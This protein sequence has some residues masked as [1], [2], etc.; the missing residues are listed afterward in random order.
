MSVAERLQ[1]A[2]DTGLA[3]RPREEGLAERAGEACCALQ[4]FRV[5]GLWLMVYAMTSLEWRHDLLRMES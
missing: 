5:Q 2:L 1:R 3:E 4:G